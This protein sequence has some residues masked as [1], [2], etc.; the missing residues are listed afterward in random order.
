RELPGHVAE[1]VDASALTALPMD[2]LRTAIS[3]LAF[4]DSEHDPVRLIA[5]APTIVARYHRR[6]QGLDPVEPDASASYAENYLAMLHGEQPS[7]QNARAFDVA[8]ILHAEHEMNAST[9]TA[10]VV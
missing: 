4:G 8:M 2:M 9:F 1:L 6:R 10:R 3:A 7:E 5:L